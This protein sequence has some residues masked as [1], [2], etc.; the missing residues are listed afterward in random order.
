MDKS[1]FSLLLAMDVWIERLHMYRMLLGINSHNNGFLCNFLK[2]SSNIHRNQANMLVV[3]SIWKFKYWMGI[4]KKWYEM[5]YFCR[6]ISFLHHITALFLILVLTLCLKSIYCLILSTWESIG[7]KA[8]NL[9]LNR[10]TKPIQTEFQLQSM[11][12][13]ITC[14]RLNRN[15]VQWIKSSI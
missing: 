2:R 4:W 13:H 15:K 7:T 9:D 12:F 8:S 1:I 5:N 6:F 14:K 10:T 11:I 3:L